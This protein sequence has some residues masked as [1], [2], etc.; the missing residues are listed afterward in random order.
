[1]LNT[2]PPS[3]SMGIFELNDAKD[4]VKIIVDDY[5]Y[6]PY[7]IGFWTV[8]LKLAGLYRFVLSKI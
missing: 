6:V 4:K 1:L 8:K 2:T 3:L 7:G 5:E